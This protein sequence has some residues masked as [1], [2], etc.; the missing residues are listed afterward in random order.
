MP[1]PFSWAVQ[2]PTR[3]VKVSVP[4]SVYLQDDFNRRLFNNLNSNYTRDYE[5][6][7]DLKKKSFSA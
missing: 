1:G 5:T 4:L 2:T 7:E 3:V 6:E